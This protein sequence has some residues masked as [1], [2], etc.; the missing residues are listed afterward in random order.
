MPL[1]N[2][3]SLTDED[4]K[5]PTLT[6]NFLNVSSAY[7]PV[8]YWKDGFNVVHLRGQVRNSWNGS[9]GLTIFTLPVGYRPPYREAFLVGCFAPLLTTMTGRID[10][11]TDGSV[12]CVNGASLGALTALLM[13]GITFRAS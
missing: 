1:N 9:Q 12:Q 6:N 3:T 13:D 11:L 7:N 8:G 10:I 2:P 4:W 5:T